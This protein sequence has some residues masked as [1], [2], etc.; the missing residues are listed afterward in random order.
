MF[1]WFYHCTIAPAKMNLQILNYCT[2]FQTEYV[3][4]LGGRQIGCML[5]EDACRSQISGDQSSLSL[6]DKEAQSHGY[7]SCFQSSEPEKSRA[8]PCRAGKQDNM[9]LLLLHS[10]SSE[11]HPHRHHPV[12]CGRHRF[13]GVETSRQAST[14][15]V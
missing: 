9:L 2:I 6:A 4:L 8:R 10:W 1:G 15:L 5:A 3:D 14:I 11:G 13:V 7:P 12:A